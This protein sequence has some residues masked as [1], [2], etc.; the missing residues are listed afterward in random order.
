VAPV[1]LGPAAIVGGF[2]GEHVNRSGVRK[3]GAV[4]V[5]V[6]VACALVGVLA[7]R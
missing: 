5:L 4:A 2:A 6:A 1:L 7:L 3:A